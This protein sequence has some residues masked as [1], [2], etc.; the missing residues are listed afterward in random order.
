MWIKVVG[1]IANVFHESERL[2]AVGDEREAAGR[3]RRECH[4]LLPQ[5]ADGIV[6]AQFRL[7]KGC[8]VEGRAEG[9]RRVGHQVAAFHRA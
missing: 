9:Q 4:G 3:V 2:M 8:S 7:R 5:V 1:T 6:V